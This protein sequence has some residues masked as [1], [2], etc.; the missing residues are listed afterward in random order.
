VVRTNARPMSISVKS[1]MSMVRKFILV[2]LQSRMLPERLLIYYLG[3]RC[4]AKNIN[5]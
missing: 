3:H 2:D 1:G 4:A 5:E